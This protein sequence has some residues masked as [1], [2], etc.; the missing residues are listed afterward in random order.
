[1]SAVS[2][3]V[4][5]KRYNLDEKDP[6]S[7]AEYSTYRGNLELFTKAVDDAGISAEPVKRVT[8]SLPPDVLSM[9]DEVAK[10]LL[11]SRSAFLSGFLR[12]SLPMALTMA[13]AAHESVD[14]DPA[15]RRYRDS[16]KADIDD[17]IKRLTT[18]GGQDDLFGG[19]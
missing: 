6:S 9:L 19:K 2:F 3:K 8:V 14:G 15:V 5:C 4:F 18:L 7:K 13:K 17:L 10:L 12:E 1:M 11:L 16:S